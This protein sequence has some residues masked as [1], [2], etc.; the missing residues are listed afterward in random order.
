MVHREW[1]K[2]HYVALV[3]LEAPKMPEIQV[4]LQTST[5]PLQNLYKTYF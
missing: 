1:K 4:P 3:L 2:K 5:K